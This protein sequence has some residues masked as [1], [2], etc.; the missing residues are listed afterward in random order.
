MSTFQF[1]MNITILV[2][3]RHFTVE[4]MASTNEDRY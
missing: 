2:G 4:Y 1:V 3:S